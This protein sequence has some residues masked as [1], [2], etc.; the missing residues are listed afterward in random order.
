MV[1][2][3]RAL[4]AGRLRRVAM[5]TLPDTLRPGTE[6]E[7]Y[8]LQAV[9][10]AEL[11][12]AGRGAVVG[13]KVGCTTPIMQAYLKIH[14]PCAGGVLAP[15][16]RDATGAFPHEAFVR[17]G[18]E[19]ELAVRLGA[20]LTDTGKPHDRASV[21]SAVAAVMAAIE[22]VDDRWVHYPSMDTPTL[23]ADDFFG[24]GCVLGD[25]VTAWRSLDLQGLAGTMAVNG[26]PVGEGHGRDIL[27]HPLEALA[28]LA[29][30][31]VGRGAALRAGEFVLLGSL[32]TT[33]WLR[34]GDR[35]TIQVEGLG[36]AEARFE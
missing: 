26:M 13:H 31:M 32:V 1:E 3:A 34:M 9:L 29:N 15:T 22:I 28:W 11:A 30:S 19:C 5:D 6:A 18:V 12:A 24:A 27:G 2:A 35:A 17:V 8:T 14:N 25:P 20:D 16:V 23:V 7:A 33:Q 36:G 21:A 4:A 10:H